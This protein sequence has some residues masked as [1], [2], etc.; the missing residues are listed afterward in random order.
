MTEELSNPRKR[1]ISLGCENTETGK[2]RGDDSATD[3]VGHRIEESF[4]DNT[5]HSYIRRI[6]LESKFNQWSTCVSRAAEGRGF[7]VQGV[8]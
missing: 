8:V 3:F 6:V 4:N 2:D 7:D 1:C 5:S